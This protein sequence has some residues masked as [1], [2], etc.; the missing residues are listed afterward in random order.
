MR[1]L[2]SRSSSL[3]VGH[4][5]TTLVQPRPTSISSLVFLFLARFLPECLFA[6]LTVRVIDNLSRDLRLRPIH[7]SFASGPLF[8]GN[9]CQI[10]VATFTFLVDLLW[11]TMERITND[12]ASSRSTDSST[13]HRYGFV[14][15][16]EHRTICSNENHVRGFSNKDLRVDYELDTFDYLSFLLGKKGSEVS[17]RFDGS[18]KKKTME[19]PVNEWTREETPSPPWNA[20]CPSCRH[21]PSSHFIPHRD[22]DIFR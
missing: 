18:R 14:Y 16:D 1:I 22:P 17:G 10:V 13:Y 20:S 2:F 15:S 3:V 12:P 11:W 5:F 21:P 4:T 7:P 9:F 19:Q 8:H 6:R